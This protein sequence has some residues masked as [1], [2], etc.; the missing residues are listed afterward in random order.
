M[1]Y[2][3]PSLFQ[4]CVGSNKLCIALT[5][6]STHLT[7]AFSFPQLSNELNEMIFSNSTMTLVSHTD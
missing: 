2:E 7:S 5:G 4:K 3:Y 1:G 6:T